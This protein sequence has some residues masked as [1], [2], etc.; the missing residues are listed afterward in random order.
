MARRRRD[1]GEVNLDSLMDA[2]TNVVA[3]LILVLMLV[4]IDVVNV[5]VELSEDLE[6]ASDEMIEEKLL[7]LKKLEDQKKDL[8]KQKE[9]DPPTP[10][11]IEEENRKLALLEKSIED[12]K[13]VLADKNE[14]VEIEKKVRKERDAQKDVTLALQKEIEEL[15]AAL[16]DT[17]VLT[18]VPPVEV[19][20]PNSRPIPPKAKKYLAICT[21]EAVHFIDPF[22]P[23]ETFEEEFKD[24]K[25]DWFHE[26]IKQD[27]ADRKVYDQVKIAKHFEKFDFK[28][29]RN[30][31]VEIITIPH[32]PRLQLKI[33]ADEKEG[34]IGTTYD[35][36]MEENNPFHQIC[37]KLAFDKENIVF[38]HVHPQGFSTY[39]QARKIADSTR[40]PAGWS[41]E[42]WNAYQILIEDIEVNKIADP[43]ETKPA[44][45]NSKPRPPRLGPKLD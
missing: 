16:D 11:M 38:F 19:T 31:K 1:D 26:R 14:L 13:Q 28:N 43:P 42:G 15:S 12:Q 9:E 27:G 34:A 17:P 32:S 40:L 25:N 24:N 33:T 39:L 20:I 29:S 23:L 37:K 22:T 21:Q 7:V 45:P 8:E 6:P 35:E 5:V 44:D 41:V 2:L 18:D 3:V 30:Q 4:Q 36:L 10:E